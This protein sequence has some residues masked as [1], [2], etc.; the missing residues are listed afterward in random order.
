MMLVLLWVVDL[1]KLKKM[2][3]EAVSRYSL[4]SNGLYSNELN[5]HDC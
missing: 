4:Y 3:I 1:I 2:I 5:E